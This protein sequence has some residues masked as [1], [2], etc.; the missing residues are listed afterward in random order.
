MIELDQIMRQQGDNKFTDILNRIRTGSLCNED[1]K[2][3]S[4]RI[5]KKSDNN[6]PREAMHIWAENKPVDSRNKEMLNLINEELVTITAHDVYP[7]NVS[8][9]DINK[10]LQRGRCS[11]GGLEYEIKLKVGSRVMLT[12]NLDV[13]DRLI[14]GQIGTVVKIRE[15]S[16]SLKPEVIY[17]KYDDENAGRVRI[18]KSGDRYAIANG[19]VP[20]MLIFKLKS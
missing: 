14:N 6:Y 20:V 16:V 13:E 10:A 2:I 12:T 5:V 4:E 3:L 1:C 8:D 7:K 19:A 17:V 18:R 9:V 15:N 11:N